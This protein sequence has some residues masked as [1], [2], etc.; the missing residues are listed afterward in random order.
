MPHTNRWVIVFLIYADFRTEDEDSVFPPFSMNEEMKVE[1]NCLFKDI[2]TTPIPDSGMRIFVIMDRITY[3][4]KEAKASVASKTILYEIANPELRPEN[5]FVECKILDNKETPVNESGTTQPLHQAEHLADIFK[6]IVVEDGEGTLLITWDHGSAF[7]IFR[8]EIFTPPEMRVMEPITSELANYPYLEKFW[9]CALQKGQLRDFIE[10]QELEKK[11]PL[12]QRSEKFFKP[13]SGISP[14]FIKGNIDNIRKSAAFATE[15][16]GNKIMLSV[17][18]VEMNEVTL[19]ESFATEQIPEI[20]RN[21]ELAKAIEAWLGKKKL[22]VLVMM[23]C[24]MM[25]LHTMH[26]LK[27][28]VECLVAPQGDIANPGYNYRDILRYIFEERLITSQDLA[29]RCVEESQNKFA[30]RRAKKL[31]IRNPKTI[32][33]WKLVAVD[34]QAEDK[35]KERLI[36]RELIM[37]KDIVSRLNVM[38]TIPE[39]GKQIDPNLILLLKHVRLLSHDFTKKRAKMVDIV[40]W[41]YTLYYLHATLPKKLLPSTVSEPIIDFR[42]SIIKSGPGKKLIIA[43]SKGRSIYE[44]DMAVLALPPT[45]YSLFFPQFK[46]KDPKVID[47]A[48]NDTLLKEFKEWKDFLTT[49]Y[50]DLGIF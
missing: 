33:T 41:L 49:L 13:V 47:N 36:D 44:T 45:G 10:S 11:S 1:L 17:A 21:D 7:G 31:N 15:I 40:N 28:Q 5:D 23:N 16:A 24:W 39:P 14:H 42:H 25:N 2:L 8:E 27:E 29:I 32:G 4:K 9:N 30:R 34:L 43:K 6:N 37:L 19:I 38:I 22:S 50:G 20:L 35:N 3:I 46:E 48:R 26:S 18:E 12:F